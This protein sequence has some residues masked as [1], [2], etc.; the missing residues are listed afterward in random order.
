MSYEKLLHVQAESYTSL[1]YR[2]EEVPC[3]S[4]MGF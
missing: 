1:V 3:K 4:T 2:K